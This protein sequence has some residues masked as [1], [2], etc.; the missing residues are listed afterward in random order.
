[1]LCWESSLWYNRNKAHLSKQSLFMS[2]MVLNTTKHLK[3]LKSFFFIWQAA[4]D[5]KTFAKIFVF[6]KFVNNII[7]SLT[8][9]ENKLAKISLSCLQLKT[10]TIVFK[11]YLY[12]ISMLLVVVF[13]TT[14]I[15]IGR[16][17][18]YQNAK[19]MGS[20]IWEHMYCHWM[21]FVTFDKSIFENEVVKMTLNSFLLVCQ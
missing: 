17:W 20:I 14:F 8:E 7:L 5:A 18:C 12:V 2:V 1:M 6:V 11:V 9:R 3:S 15:S 21:R 4:F 10:V 13:F 19:V 16:E